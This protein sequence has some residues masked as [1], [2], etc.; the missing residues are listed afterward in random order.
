MT[1]R[2]ERVNVLLREELSDRTPTVEEIAVVERILRERIPV[3]LFE[4]N[5]ERPT[6]RSKVPD[7][8]GGEQR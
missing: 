8:Q 7:P 1:R 6:R 3:I 2:T 4:K 5:L